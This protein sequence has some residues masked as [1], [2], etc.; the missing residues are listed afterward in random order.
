VEH[1]EVPIQTTDAVASLDAVA[2]AAAQRGLT[3][4][5]GTVTTI[6]QL[7]AAQGAGVS[8]T[9]SPGLD[10][11][12]IEESTRRGIPHLPGVGTASEIL[13]ARAL[14]LIWLKAFPASVLGTGWVKA[15][16]GPF[17]EVCFVGTGGMTVSNADQ[18]LAAGVSV[19]GL[20]SAFADDKN[21]ED[22]RRLIAR[23]RAGADA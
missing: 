9:V 21:L 23:T 20:S 2:R 4:G 11:A 17:P 10:V 3:V 8:F 18:F 13:Q 14:G 19:V 7:D 5:A 16:K 6:E 22:V 12:I 1:V 15:M